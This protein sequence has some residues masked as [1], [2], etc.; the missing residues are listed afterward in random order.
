MGARGRFCYRRLRRR[1]EFASLTGVAA[2]RFDDMV[3]R[4]RPIWGREVVGA[5]AEDGRPWGVGGLEDHLLV[6][7]ILY[8]CHLTRDVLGRLHGV[9]TSAIGRSKGRVERIAA[10]ALGVSRRILVGAAGAQAPIVDGTEQPV[11]RPRRKQ[12]CYYS[13]KRRRHTLKAELVATHHEGRTRIAAIPPPA[14]PT[15]SP[16]AAGGRPCPRAAGSRPTAPTRATRRSTRRPRAPTGARPAGAPPRTSGGTTARA[17]APACASSTSSPASNPSGSSG[18]SSAT[19]APPT[20]PRSAAS[21]AAS[22]SRPASDPDD[23]EPTGHP[24]CPIG[25]PTFAT[26]LL[27]VRLEFQ[28]QVFY[29]GHSILAVTR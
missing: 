24:A 29:Q 16:C 19:P 21:P 7:L 27:N 2:D 15:T 9:D 4:L 22:T 5:K 6:L 10:K 26:G 18:T 3:R 14:A 1:R 13:G 12:R 20:T 25:Q 11:R 17:Q 28:A 8:R 23:P